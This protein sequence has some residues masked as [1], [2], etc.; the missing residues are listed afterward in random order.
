MHEMALAENILNLALAEA[1]KQGCDI[2]LRARVEYGPL[3][4]IMPDA[5]ELCFEALARQAGQESVKLELE[6]LPMKL[7]CPFC[8]AEFGGMDRDAIWQPCPACGEEFGHTVI[9]GKELVLAR[10]EACRSLS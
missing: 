1:A 10:I 8:K 9:Q 7:R 6:C 5:L 2:L 4:G 3:T